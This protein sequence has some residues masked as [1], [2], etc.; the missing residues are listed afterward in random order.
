M[1]SLALIMRAYG[2]PVDEVK[3]DG[4]IVWKDN[5]SPTKSQLSLAHDLR[6]SFIPTQL[7]VSKDESAGRPD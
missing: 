1:K 5:F 2:L 6:T 7:K 4:E 3:D